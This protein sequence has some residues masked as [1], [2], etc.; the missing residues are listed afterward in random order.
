[1]D[2]EGT[3]VSDPADHQPT[4]A[5]L[6]ADVSI[7]ATPEALAWAV[8][9]GG[10]DRRPAGVMGMTAATTATGE[11][12]DANE[13]SQKDGSQMPNHLAAGLPAPTPTP[14]EM[15]E[16]L[17]KLGYLVPEYN[18]YYQPI[19]PSAYQTVPNITTADSTY[20]TPDSDG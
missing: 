10:T 18:E 17:T 4:K 5:E 2:A 6:E 7:D 13:Q 14:T 8:T 19:I 20:T 15:L 16:E 11:I 9:R 1:M 3:R 12:E